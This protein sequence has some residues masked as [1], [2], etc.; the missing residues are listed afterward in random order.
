MSGNGIC[1]LPLQSSTRPANETQVAEQLIRYPL[2][3]RFLLR[4]RLQATGLLPSFLTTCAG[5]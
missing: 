1:L 5:T 2:I 4:E 3:A